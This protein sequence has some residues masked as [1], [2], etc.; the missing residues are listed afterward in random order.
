MKR[1]ITIKTLIIAIMVTAI[2]SG[3]V[4]VIAVKLSAKDVGFTASNEEWQVNNVEDAVNDLYKIGIDNSEEIYIAKYFRGGISSY[5]LTA[6]IG[7]DIYQNIGASSSEN[8]TI[9]GNYA[10]VTINAANF[11]FELTALVD[12]RLRYNTSKNQMYNDEEFTEITLTAGET[13][14]GS[15]PDKT[16]TG[17]VFKVLP[18]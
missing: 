1:K 5:A 9:S 18:L 8:G 4:G 3:T 2:L 7:D 11:T 10:T 17:T 6:M 13:Y 16:I 12:I 14:N 15:F